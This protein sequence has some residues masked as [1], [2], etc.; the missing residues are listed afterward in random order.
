MRPILGDYSPFDFGIVSRAVEAGEQAALAAQ[1][2]LLALA[3]DAR[4]LSSATCSGAPQ[5]RQAPPLI[6]F[7]RIESGSERYCRRAAQAL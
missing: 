2:E 5:A 4:L 1:E 7:V 3:A 6:E